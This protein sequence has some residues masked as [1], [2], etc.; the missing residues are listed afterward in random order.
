MLSCKLLATITRVLISQEV[1][2]DKKCEMLKTVSNEYDFAIANGH[3]VWLACVTNGQK[4]LLTANDGALA[5]NIAVTVG[6]HDG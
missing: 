3:Q 6:T 5:C 2:G 4:Q 1:I